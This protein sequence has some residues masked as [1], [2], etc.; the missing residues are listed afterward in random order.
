MGAKPRAGLVRTAV[1]RAPC[2]GTTLS[3]SR[4]LPRVALPGSLC[5]ITKGVSPLSAGTRENRGAVEQ[6]PRVLGPDPR[7]SNPVLGV[8]ADGLAALQPE[9][10]PLGRPRRKVPILVA[11]TTF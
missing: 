2:D 3:R 7:C 11:P 1:W 6:K 9:T 5:C 10:K 4:P 8:T